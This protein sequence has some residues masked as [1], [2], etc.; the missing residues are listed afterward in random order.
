M[1]KSDGERC[2]LSVVAPEPDDLH[3]AVT[4]AQVVQ[5]SHGSVRTT[6]INK[7]DFVPIYPVQTAANLVVQFP[8]G[9][10]LVIERHNDRNFPGSTVVALLALTAGSLLALPV[11]LAR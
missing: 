7:D 4:L 2:G 3:T 9:F 10:L 1:C 6:I 11:L 8:Q 5:H